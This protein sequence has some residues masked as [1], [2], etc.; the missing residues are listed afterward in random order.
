M[1]EWVNKIMQ[2]AGLENIQYFKRIFFSRNS[3][4]LG[5]QFAGLALTFGCNILL[6]RFYGDQNYGIFSL[7]SGWAILFSVAG[8]FGMD[9]RHLARVPALNLKENKSAIKHELFSSL[10]INL[11]SATLS[12]LLFYLLIR[13]SG[14]PVFSRHF[15]FFL[16]A[17]LLIPCYVFMYNLLY[18]LRA[19]KGIIQGEIADKLVRPVAFAV[20][21]LGFFYFLSPG[22]PSKALAANITGLVVVIFLLALFVR[23]SLF[24]MKDSAKTENLEFMPARNFRYTVLNLLYFLSMRLDILVLGLF[25]TSS[26]VGHYTI[27]SRFGDIFSYPVAMLNL[28]FPALLSEK[29]HHQDLEQASLLPFKMARN[30]FWLCLLTGILFIFFA[31]WIFSLFGKN[32]GEATSVLPIFLIATLVNASAGLSDVFFIVTGNER[33]VIVCRVISVFVTA[34]CALISVP[35][36]GMTGAAWSMLTGNVLYYVSIQFYYWKAHHHFINPFFSP[37]TLY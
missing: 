23:S 14:I 9:D 24:K 22:T 19:M 27:A 34:V 1:F 33:K 5:L 11:V 18:F 32:F 6:A 10:K 4:A 25:V 28:S 7:V 37:G 21:A 13:F 8:L 17:L 16:Y 36:F 29:I 31:P 35:R 20:I 26:E 30:A 15:H 12:V 3:L 2:F